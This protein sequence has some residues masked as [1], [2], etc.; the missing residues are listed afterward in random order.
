MGIDRAPAFPISKLPGTLPT[1]KIDENVDPL[2]IAQSCLIH[3]Q[4]LDS[5]LLTEDTLWRDLFS[6]TGTARTFHGPERIQ[7][8]WRDLCAVHKP[9]QFALAPGGVT[10]ARPAP[11]LAW[12]NVK[13][14]FKTQGNPALNCT[15]IMRLIP[16]AQQSWRIWT[17]VTILQGI[18]GF[19]NVDILEPSMDWRTEL[20]LSPVSDVGED[21][22]QDCV[23]VGAG[24]SGL[25]TAG[26]LKAAGVNAI[27]LE[28]NAAVGQNWTDRYDSVSIHT[29]KACGQ[30]PFKPTWDAS[31]PYHLKISDLESGYKKF[32][33]TYALDVWLSSNMEKA[34][35]SNKTKTWTLMVNRQG[36]REEVRS[37]HLVLAI[38]GGGTVPKIPH[39]AN[40]D[41][42]K[43][44]S[45]HSVDYKNAKQWAGLR[46]VVI[47]SANSGHDIT[48]DM[49]EAGCSSV[50]MVQR[51]TTPV[52]PVEYYHKI[53]DGI[54]N[55]NVP[56]NIS[57]MMMISP[58]T[59]VT[60]LMAMRAISKMASEE[61]ERFDSLERR[62][63]KVDRDM[64]LYQCLYERFGGHYLDVGV[65]TKISQGLIKMKSDSALTGFTESGLVFADGSTLDADV[66]VF[67]TGFEGNMRLAARDL[68]DE[69]VADKLED[70][71]GVDEEG[72]LRGAWKPIGRK[73]LRR[74]TR[75]DFA[76]D[77]SDPGIWFTGG[78]VMLA[79][80]FSRFLA[81]QIAADVKDTPL[82]V[83]GKK[84]E[85]VDEQ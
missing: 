49:L 29:S 45:L 81:L 77:A 51:G 73:S 20:P 17:L 31:T 34:H 16:D 26:Y 46:G 12:I 79:R 24:M 40:R 5:T 23:V 61:P 62:G 41:K 71:W 25:C 75:S 48:N 13:F 2:P 72:E 70:W 57:D 28:K 4:L 84:E 52:L 37:R 15:G 43:G 30:L 66:V 56:V 44:K 55:D 19:P 54:Y 38:G 9:F 22:V 82:Q 36:M 3:L 21:S 58:P 47:G 80:F 32:V 18:D 64:D 68:V 42:F 10:I 6:L 27:I 39:V 67:A 78:N 33:K 74:G 83:Y 11:T 50:T 59:A 60:R 7:K 76:D 63:F 69:D 85:I 8:T 53:Y 1:S 65:S 14:S 35:W